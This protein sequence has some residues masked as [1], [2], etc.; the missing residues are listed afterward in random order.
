MTRSRLISGVNIQWPWS[1]LILSRKKTV[2][3]RAYPLP[4][5]HIGKELAIIE[6][7]GARGKEQAG[8]IKARIIGTITF[9]E[10]FQYTSREHWLKDFKHH[11]VEVNDPLFAYRE[12]APKWGWPIEKVVVFQKPLSAPTKRGII[13]ATNC[14]I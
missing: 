3:T 6:T 5:H 1:Q 7:P 12:N 11:R 10:S 2:E 8:I 4:K 13:F 14:K 9:K